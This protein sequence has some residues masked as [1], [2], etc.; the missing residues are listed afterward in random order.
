MSSSSSVFA[1]FNRVLTP[2]VRVQ[3]GTVS[4]N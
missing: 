2:V 3:G 4:I 1:L